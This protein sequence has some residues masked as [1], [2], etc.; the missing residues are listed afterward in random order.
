MYDI[1]SILVLI[2]FII[3]FF[4][5]DHYQAI[6]TYILDKE[7]E[8]TIFYGEIKNNLEEECPGL[9]FELSYNLRH[10]ISVINKI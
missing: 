10:T 1:K 7:K 2:F 3:L 8:N 4:I 6:K 5:F 9:N